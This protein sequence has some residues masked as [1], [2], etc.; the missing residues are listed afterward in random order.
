M[1]HITLPSRSKPTMRMIARAGGYERQSQNPSRQADP[2]IFCR[3]FAPLTPPRGRA[4]SMALPGNVKEVV[5]S[6]ATV[7]ALLIPLTAGAA[8]AESHRLIAQ[9]FSL[10]G[11]GDLQSAIWADKLPQ[12]QASRSALQRAAPSAHL[13]SI[14]QVWTATF[15]GNGRS[16]VVSAI[17]DGCESSSAAENAL[18][19]PVRVAEVVG[20]KVQVVADTTLPISSVRGNAG[21]DAS[22]NA[23]SQYM[24]IASFDPVSR[25]IS[26]TDVSAGQ[27][28]AL[29]VRVNLR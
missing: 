6:A 19:C 15:A 22:S 28:T 17:N 5:M 9:E 18:I 23:N 10:V 29:S 2:R 20:G 16:Y 25:A 13:K 24:T 7:I 14:A 11:A 4:V 26:F 8:Q 3:R 21:Y 1:Q 12:L 27:K